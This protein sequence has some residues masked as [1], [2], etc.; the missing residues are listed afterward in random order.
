MQNSVVMIWMFA[1]M[2]CTGCDRSESTTQ[3]HEFSLRV[4]LSPDVFSS[5]QP[6]SVNSVEL[7]DEP[8]TL[9][10]GEY[11]CSEFGEELGRVLTK[12]VIWFPQIEENER[13]QIKWIKVGH[14]DQLSDHIPERTTIMEAILYLLVIS[15][16]M[17]Y[18]FDS[19]IDYYQWSIRPAWVA[20]PYKNVLVIIAL[21]AEDYVDDEKPWPRDSSETNELEMFLQEEE[22]IFQEQQKEFLKKNGNL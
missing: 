3:L 20:I 13:D 7:P 6:W 2:V 4:I 15:T 9:A 12:T 19:V 16:E 17:G 14:T 22:R 21:P 1:L 10:P 8:I 11:S 18:G 5:T